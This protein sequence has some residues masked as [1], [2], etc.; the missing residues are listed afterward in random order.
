MRTQNLAGVL[1]VTVMF[2]A[3]ASADPVHFNTSDSRFDL[4]VDNQG[5]WSATRVNVDWNDSYF[6]GL[7][8][9]SAVCTTVHDNRNFF[10]FDLSSLTGSVVSATLELRHASSQSSSPAFG[11][12]DVSTDP[13]TLNN[14]TGTSAAIFD[15]LGTGKSYGVFSVPD[16]L[17]DDLLRFQL[18]AAAIADI[19]ANAGG[20]FS[21]GGAILGGGFAFGTSNGSSGSGIQR[22]VITTE[23]PA[24]VPEPATL[25]YLII[26]AGVLFRRSRRNKPSQEIEPH[27]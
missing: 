14:N 2:A 23:S 16:G 20:F 3:P 5:W 9:G 21:I 19:Q 4:G 26:G 13:V 7:A 11:L 17:P 27:R 12:F 8:C 10:T 15:D 22:L 6:V 1:W 25:T 18:N 24:P